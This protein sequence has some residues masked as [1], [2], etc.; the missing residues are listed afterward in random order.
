M[1]KL[2]IT[3]FML[4]LCTQIRGQSWELGAFGGGVGYMGDLNPDNI[5]KLSN[6]AY[7]LL[8]KRN[9]N[10][11]WAIKLSF[12]H[13]KIKE[14][15]S[16][17]SNLHQQQRNLSFITPLTEIS[18]QGEFN[19]FDYVPSMSKKRFS[20]YLFAGAALTMFNPKANVNGDLV[21][22]NPLRTENKEYRKYTLSIPYGAGVK[23]NFS[24][25]W[26]LGAEL[27]YR[28]SFSDHMDD[29]SGNYPSNDV[30]YPQDG[31]PDVNLTDRSEEL[32][33]GKLFS[34]GRQRGDSKGRDRYF[35]TGITLSYTFMK[36]NC[37]P[38]F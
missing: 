21:E 33:E 5:F 32:G 36:R 4:L 31:L 6:P 12:M 1:A 37:P 18:F 20:P 38:V 7:G 30:Y 15:D 22:L 27:G 2:G 29:V 16:L 14:A 23:Y 17:S 3:F 11:R 24:R 26:T 34:A 10:S 9:I 35:F 19:F 25:M 28:T 8:V 13:G